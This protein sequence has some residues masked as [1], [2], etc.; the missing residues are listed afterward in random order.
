MKMFHILSKRKG[1]GIM[2]KTLVIAEKPDAAKK[3]VEALKPEGSFKTSQGYYESDKYVVT[4]GFGHL[5]SAKLP[6]E[7]TEFGGWKWEAIPFYPPSGSLDYKIAEESKKKQVKTVGD[8]LK[9][10]DVVDIVNAC[11]AGREGDLIF[12]E[13]YDYFKNKKPVKRLWI[14]SLVKKDIQ[15]GF[16]NLK[17]GSFFMP[18][19]EAAYARQYADWALGMNLTVGFSIKANMGRALHVGRVQTPTIAILA[20]RRLEMENFK[21]EEYFEIEVDFGNKYKGRWFKDQKG[22]TKF[23]KKE[24]AQLIVDKVSGKIGTVTVKDVV[25]DK[26]NPKTLYDLGDLQV[27]ANRKFGF[28][29]KK[30]LDI[31]QLLYEKYTILS[32]PR[33]DSKHLGTVHIPEL[34]PTLNAI[35]IPQYAK[36]VDH[37]L[38]EG[39]KTSKHFIDDSKVSDHH[40]LIP[41]DLTPDLSAVTDEP[42]AGIRRD[43][44]LKIY[45]LVVK[46]F[47]AVFYPPALYEKTEIVTT[48]EDETFKTSGKIL[49]S[50]GW[51]EIYGAEVEEDEEEE[52]TPKKG[53]NQEE[54]VKVQKLPPIDLNETNPA[55]EVDLQEKTTKAPTPYTEGKLIGV[56]KNPR[57]LLDDEGLKKAMKEAGAGLGTQ[58][59]RQD[60]I[61]NI[62]SRGYVER[63]G[64]T[65][66]ATDLAMKL[67]HIAPE[68]LKSPEITAEWEQKLTNIQ[69]DKITRQEF[70]IDIREYVLKNLDELKNK[71]LTVQFS[72]NDDKEAIGKCPTCGEEVYEFPK[73]FACATNTREHQCF[74][75]FKSVA[76]KTITT[77]QAKDLMEKGQTGLIKG[78]K[79]TKGTK[80]DAKLQLVQ[81]KV[82]FAFEQ[83]APKETNLTCPKCQGKMIERDRLF[84]CEHSTQTAPC[85]AVFKV[86]AGKNID[87][88]IVKTLLEKGETDV[89]SGFKSSK[90]K[91]FSAKLV[92]GAKGV[93][94]KFD[95]APASQQESKDLNLTCPVCGDGKMVENA[96]AYGCSNWKEKKC[97]FSIWKVMSG[98]KIT[99]KIVK[100]LVMNQKTGKID[101]FKSAKGSAFSAALEVDKQNKKVVFN[102]E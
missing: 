79:S 102:F 14:S 45:D 53:K 31:A 94:F 95:D 2:S 19:R 7:Y 78:F 74:V 8:L 6:K 18:R 34:E 56:M 5:F 39:I 85:T 41:T 36:F 43:D 11:D 58:A 69:D 48:V 40:A 67:I 86:I 66:M 93:E 68:E 91:P 52:E 51:K 72:R 82:Q 32:Y 22:N 60:I 87:Q 64:K 77:K 1:D 30:T 28:T 3:I 27:E 16:K 15:N 61:E 71:E 97:T 96:K 10:P 24:D 73:V 29:A 100:E 9:R 70:E 90:G 35:R 50:A 13:M 84:V 33:T 4:Y 54:K 47:L 42:K 75:I 98:K 37:I 55:Q 59:T 17:E 92:W 81:G 44:I 99:E 49:I 20:Q 65:L 62:I 83:N 76:G 88:K 38:D 12:W 101:G 23:D 25:E 57:S 63:K 80:F 89:L 46:R 26:E 21:P